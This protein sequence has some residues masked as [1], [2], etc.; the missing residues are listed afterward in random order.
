M[1]KINL[2]SLTLAALMLGACSEEVEM[3]EN[4]NG[5]DRNAN[6]K[7]YVSLAI[8]LPTQPGTRVNDQYAD[9]T[10]AEY[11]VKNATLILFVDGVISSA[12][13]MNLNFSPNGTNDNVTTTAKITQEINNI[14]GTDPDI[15]ALVVLNRNGMVSVDENG[16]ILKVGTADMTGKD[17][18]ALNDAVRDAI[19]AGYSWHGDGLLM[20]NAVLADAPGGATDASAANIV[21]PLVNI[22]PDMI[23]KTRAEADANPAAVIYVERA[24]AKVTLGN[25]SSGTV[26][27]GS[28][29]EYDIEGWVIDNYNMTNKLVRDVND[30]ET[31]KAYSSTRVTVPDYRFIGNVSV[32]A[33]SITPYY[34]VYWGDDYNYSGVLTNTGLSTMGGANAVV[35]S[36]VAADGTTPQYCFENTTDLENM[37]E[38]NLTRVIVK[39]IFNEGAAFYTVDGDRSIIWTEENVKKEAAA[40]LL[41]DVKFNEWAVANVE[42]G[43]VLSSETDFDVAFSG[44]VAGTRTITSITLNSTGTA[45]LKAGAA[46]YPADAAA[47]ANS[48]ITMDYYEGGA[49]YYPVYIKHFGDDQTPWAEE[50]QPG[51]VIY[52]NN[53]GD[54]LGRYAVLRNNWYD[55]NVTSIKSLGDP[56]VVE[57][58]DEPVDKKESF[59]SVQ[60]NV[61]AWAKRTQ[62]VDL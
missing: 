57:V 21:G 50:H 3:F 27:N 2:L 61:L 33:T 14:S 32:P 62:N 1:K 44:E 15:K 59:I 29:L 42:P 37:V 41:T 56:N 10:P 26:T 40:R 45:K 47:M 17:L 60:I 4:N 51:N 11:E 58:T 35:A 39:A 18:A 46:T 28:N 23:K 30:F 6:G 31:W 12:Y 55:I 9:G 22:D 19:T 8:Q 5:T 20:S 38:R 43:Q 52:G 53:P 16:G 24:E 13:D 7:G 25:S 49:S 54:Y 48:H 36:T 34:R